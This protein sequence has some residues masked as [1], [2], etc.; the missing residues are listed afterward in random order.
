MEKPLAWTGRRLLVTWSFVA[1]ALASLAAF[2]ALAGFYD[3]QGDEPPLPALGLSRRLASPG[4]CGNSQ[5]EVTGCNT[6]PCSAAEHPPLDCTW[7]A[8]G[9]WSQCECDGFQVRTRG[10]LSAARNGGQLCSGPG[11]Q[12]QPCQSHCAKSDVV[13]CE[14]GSWEP[15]SD[16]T[17][18]CLGGQQYRTRE[19]V[20]Q[21]KAGGETCSGP[22]DETR[23]CST[24]ECPGMSRQDCRWDDWSDW[25]TCSAS[26]GDG[27][28]MR[29]RI[30]KA[31]PQNGGRLCE[32]LTKSEMARCN[33]G[34]C[35]DSGQED[36]LWALWKP[37]SACSQTCGTGES[38][39]T[40]A[41]AR[42]AS[43]GG[44]GCDG[45][46]E[47]YQPCS[48]A[49]CPLWGRACEFGPWTKWSDCSATCQGHHTRARSIAVQAELGGE[50]CTGGLEETNPCNAQISCALLSVDCAYQSWLPWSFCSRSCGGG[51][52]ARRRGIAK[53][54]QGN[55]K[56]CTG[57]LDEVQQCNQHACIGM[58]PVDCSWTSWGEWSECTTTC[59]QGERKRQRSV[60]LEAQNDGRPCDGGAAVE[61][62]GCKQPL[63]KSLTD[64]CEWSDWDA[65][66]VCTRSGATVTC[67]G[68]QQKRSRAS[69]IQ[70]EQLQQLD[71]G[72]RLFSPRAIGSTS[73]GATGRRLISEA[74]CRDFQEEL[75]GCAEEPCRKTGP[76]DCV[77]GAWEMWGTCPCSGMHQ[78]Y[79]SI[80]GAAKYG[81]K[82]CEGPE[83]E[84]APCRSDCGKMP[85]KDCQ[86]SKWTEWSACPVTCGGGRGQEGNMVRYRVITQYAQGGGKHCQGSEV[87]T[88]PCQTN[89]CP[90]TTDCKWGDWSEYSA[91]TATCGG[92]MKSRSRHVDQLAEH[93]GRACS[94]N[95]TMT[96]ETCNTEACPK[97]IRNCEWSMWND[98]QDCSVPC[99]GGMQHRSRSTL[100]EATEGGQPCNG[101]KQEF[102]QCATQQ[103]G[104]QAPI[105]CLWGSWAAWSACTALCNG[106]QERHRSLLQLPKKGGKVCEGPE[107]VIRACNLD[108]STCRSVAPQDCEIGEWGHWSKCSH[109]CDGGQRF[110][111][112]EVKV[113]AKN[114]GKPCNAALAHTGACNTQPCAGEETRQDCRWRA[115]ED[116]DACTKSC[117]GGQRTRIRK[118]FGEAR[119]YGTACKAASSMEVEPCSTQSCEQF[120]ESCGWS[121]WTAFGSCTRT[122][123]SGQQWRLRQKQLQPNDAAAHVGRRLQLSQHCSGTQ[124]QIRPC[125]LSPCDLSASPV[126]CK[127]KSWG[128]WGECLCNG[129]TSR[130]RAVEHQP[131]HGGLPC[132]G[133][134]EQSKSCEPALSCSPL[135]VDCDFGV[136]TD[137]SKCSASCGGG[138]SYHTRTVVKHA[139]AWGQGCHG[140]LEE[141]SSCGTQPCGDAQDCGYT[142]WTSWSACSRSCGGGQRQR[143]RSI[144]RYPRGGGRACSKADLQQLGACSSQACISAVFGKVD[145]VWSAW[146]SWSSC[147]ATCGMGQVRRSRLVVQE[148]SHGGQPCDGFY[149]EFHNCSLRPCPKQ[150][151]K[152]S[153]WTPWTSCSD[154]CT[155]HQSR[156]RAYEAFAIGGGHACT[157]PLK[158]MKPCHAT[159][160]TFCLSSGYSADC[161][162]SDWSPWSACSR[163][164]GGGQHTSSRQVWKEP[165]G[166]GAPCVAS[167]KRVEPCNMVFCPGDQPL[168]CRLGDWGG[169]RACTKSCGGGEMRRDRGVATEPRNGGK[170][171]AAGELTEV[172]PCNT[173]PCNDAAVCSW[174]VWTPWNLCSEACGGGEMKRHRTMVSSQLEPSQPYLKLE[175]VRSQLDTSSSRMASLLQQPGLQLGAMIFVCCGIILYVIHSG[176]SRSRSDRVEGARYMALSTND[177]LALGGDDVERP[178]LTMDAATTSS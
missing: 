24:Q 148:Q 8:W 45:V 27:E 98:W 9:Q 143:S 47:D 51:T 70:Q 157:G 96:V 122:C 41:I 113:H 60:A 106:H 88:E 161:E 115:W 176:F 72:E 23:V 39:R 152:L 90:E 85:I 141:V 34:S 133:P 64:V 12:L 178:A 16:C 48:Q 121:D 62:D 139:E 119:G 108:S 165:R 21:N 94:R 69:M 76:V 159:N 153:T 82:P 5:E 83:E 112:R 145:C 134:L 36:C 65:W 147:P 150:D 2:V 174:T 71:S 44:A 171:C 103:C 135:N 167:L 154:R 75:K 22:L 57:D 111:S 80:A 87:E 14:L 100:V 91:C 168:D 125:G 95:Y 42:E 128:D 32:A 33:L 84:S 89:P 54:A 163:E 53:N 38:V 59:G 117:D 105:P 31:Q 78:R 92:G 109:A 18:S 10:M 1:A 37:W 124:K 30:I 66:T 160:L 26:C 131:R 35:I 162:L 149:Q 101:T 3:L 25:D 137:W 15:W 58:E 68:G 136:W 175:D 19:I 151:C 52:R 43:S 173:R 123:G 13:D 172:V 55:G 130:V 77:W 138:N 67:G 6:V 110:R 4:D 156:S 7:A 97:L 155:G 177:P 126:P 61:L 11:K 116:W 166:G 93:G 74:S 104:L 20:R 73:S 170:P 118:I 142:D 120:T 79:R 127:W 132:V 17:R 129:L 50:P 56:Q 114:M 146:T 86:F 107:K 28:T 140:S 63:C 144:S 99:G 164:C 169:Y 81:G 29:S 49:P 158:E 40:R 46:F 102:Q